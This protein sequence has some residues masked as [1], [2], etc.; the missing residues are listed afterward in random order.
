VGDCLARAGIR[1]AYDVGSDDHLFE[2][3]VDEL[4]RR[5]VRLGWDA[6]IL[7]GEWDSFYGYLVAS[8]YKWTRNM[9]IASHLGLQLD[10]GLQRDIPPFR[11]SDQTST[12]Y[13]VLRAV[14]H[15]V[16]RSGERLQKD[17]VS[18]PGGYRVA[19]TPEH[20]IYH[21]ASP[22]LFEIGR[23]GAVDLSVVREEEVRT[24][25]PSRPD[26]DGLGKS[27]ALPSGEVVS[28][29]IGVTLL[30]GSVMLWT[31]QR[32][33]RWACRNRLTLLV[34][35]FS[36]VV[37][38]VAFWI[39]GGPTMLMAHHDEGEPFSWTN[40]IS[41][42]PT[43]IFPL[44]VTVLCII[45]FVKA[46]RD[47]IVNEDRIAHEFS[48]TSKQRSDVLPSTFWTNLRR[49]YHPTAKIATTA[50]QAWSW[51]REAGL[52]GQRGFRVFILFLLYAGVMIPLETWIFDEGFIRPCR[53]PFSCH[54][55]HVLTLTSLSLVVL[56]N[57]FVFDAVL[58]CR[59][60]IGWLGK[61]ANEW[62]EEFRL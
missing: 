7:I 54:I 33:W 26:L 2:S 51:Y 3:L 53:G 60:W 35:G 14:N 46:S 44:V 11:G 32:V 4:E 9:I 22:R 36:S 23:D 62:P 29:V 56:L 45:F 48:F 21:T 49:V 57:L 34:V 19:L 47:L 39:L 1:L 13:A 42:W 18:C 31:Q 58:L 61:A 59:R 6:V 25:H 15:V 17:R 8:E 41:I 50:D 37:A 55:D 12:Y 43:E 5:Q 28:A 24:I 40:G 27:A 16:C 10:G 30:I 52:P 20:R 38:G